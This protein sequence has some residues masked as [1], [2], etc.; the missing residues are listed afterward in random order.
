METF[1]G[2]RVSGQK[3]MPNQAE[4]QIVGMSVEKSG[5]RLPVAGCL[6]VWLAAGSWLPRFERSL[7]TAAQRLPKSYIHY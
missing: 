3:N 5:Y 1:F 7:L 4:R 2:I 6:F